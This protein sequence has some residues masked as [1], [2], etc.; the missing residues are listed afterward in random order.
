MTAVTDLQEGKKAAALMACK[1]YMR[2]DDDEDDEEILGLMDA[3]AAYLA[4]AGIPEPE[5]P[6][7]LYSLAL[8]SLTLH[9]YDHRDEIGAAAPLPIGL[10]PII[11]QLKLVN[12]IT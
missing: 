12:S 5:P 2:V 6:T 10:R 4:N 8:N 9:Y 7:P 1:K 11:N 3:A